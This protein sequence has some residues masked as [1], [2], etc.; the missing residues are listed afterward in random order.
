MKM[1][2]HKSRGSVDTIELNFQKP[3]KKIN[4]L[5]DS[6]ISKSIRLKKLKTLL[7]INDKKILE[8]K[9]KK[10][11]FSSFHMV[12]E[13]DKY[14][15]IQKKL[16]NTI[17][18][19][20]IK[21]LDNYKFDLDLNDLKT[22]Q[23]KKKHR[24]KENVNQYNNKIDDI[25][26]NK[27]R[28]TLKNSRH[29]QKMSQIK[30]LANEINRKIKRIHN[31]YDSFGEDESDK[32][33]EQGNYG[34][35]PR[36][37]FI[38]IYDIFLFL[39]SEF[40]LL[41][42]PYRLAK[43]KMIIE[44]NEYFILSLIIFSEFVFILDLIFGFFRWFYNNEFKL[45]SNIYLIASNYLTGNFI[46]DLIMAI[47]FY[48]IL[49]YKESEKYEYNTAYNESHFWLKIL[50]CFKALKIFKINK[51]KN[52]QVF[53]FFNKR[54][55]K[56]YYIERLYQ[57]I[58]FILLVCSMLHLI[59]CFHIYMAEQSYPNW[60]VSFN[61]QDKSFIE[62]YLASFYFIIA[63]ITSVGYGDI[64]CISSEERYFQI[65]LLSIG[66]V[67]Y[68]WIISAV[69]DYVKNKSRAMDNFN[70][71]MTKLEE[72]RIAYPNMPFKLYNKIQQHIQRMLTQNKKYEYNILVNSLPYYLQNSLLYQIHK[73]EINK[74]T[75]FKD[76]DN[77]DFIL[78]VLTHFIPI[79]SK[80]NIVLVGEGECYENIFFIKE[81]RLSLEAI[82][83]LDYIE[84]SIEKYLKYRFEEIEE[85][86]DFSDHENTNLKSSI[87]DTHKPIIKKGK[88]KPKKLIGM[89]NKQFENVDDI[90]DMNDSNIEQE[91]G[92]CDFHTEKQ[93]I[94]KGNIEYIHILDLLKN[95][96][97]GEILMFLNI[98]NPLSLKVKSKRVEL[99]ILRKKDA[100]N[101][102]KDYQNIWQRIN[103]K[104]I[105]NIK[106]LKSLTLDIINRYCEMNGII[107]KD[108]Q[109]VK[110]GFRTS[111]IETVTNKNQNLFMAKTK[112]KS[113]S[114]KFDIGKKN[115]KR[116]SL[117]SVKPT[118]K[119]LN[120]NE[121]SRKQKNQKDKFNAKKSAKNI[122][123]LNLN[124]NDKDDDDNKNKKEIIKR[125]SLTANFDKGKL[126]KAKNES[127]ESS[128]SSL[129]L[130][131]NKKNINKKMN[132]PSTKKDTIKSNK[133]I[134][135]KSINDKNKQQYPP[136]NLSPNVSKSSKCLQEKN[137]IS[138]NQIQ[139]KNS[140]NFNYIKKESKISFQINSSYKNINEVSKGQYI[141]NS[142]FQNL[143]QKIIK[144]CIK[145]KLI[146]KQIKNSDKF[147]LIKNKLNSDFFKISDNNNN[148]IKSPKESQKNKKPNDI[149]SLLKGKDIIE[150]HESK[151]IN[152]M[153]QKKEILAEDNNINGS[154][155][156]LN[157]DNNIKEEHV[158]TF[159]KIK[160]VD[161]DS[162]NNQEITKDKSVE[163]IYS[164]KVIKNEAG[165]NF[166]EVNLNYVNNFCYIY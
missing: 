58:N 126:T 23:Q 25:S 115:V 136:K 8:I 3:N 121:N 65:I 69:G 82:I 92:K 133:F 68:S 74:F 154:H 64:V 129:S 127:S 24:S 66:L 76:C 85:I 47:P 108:N 91:I 20:S 59:I 107:V 39:A 73:N 43:T 142:S 26:I 134:K 140:Y 61:L 86:E 55:S 98:P 166:Q 13:N 71:D 54:F 5:K 7:S 12:G 159:R 16:Q 48:S 165:S 97:F 4:P 114:N 56:N 101:I 161:N 116:A 41:Y 51:S 113:N 158:Q 128:T 96:Y 95:E 57:I 34:L 149:H 42:M 122:K 31:L 36:S 125:R 139:L 104:S 90:T 141:N 155:V 1:S 6:S 50:I 87:K 88:I 124:L 33:K 132:K 110:S 111:L 84:M 106:S 99:Y 28:P 94:Y 138:N 79:F 145:A 151:K 67:A 37:I 119:F 2:L 120:L 163:N 148:I 100:F 143:I 15:L 131:V 29:S 156:R 83:D 63:T 81:G 44:S 89:I 144:Y 60:I 105:H 9:S 19:L 11:K 157:E 72:I 118:I 30:Q 40:C 32:D 117:T 62:I 10:K 35:N 130:S 38:D 75:F 123:K 78:K 146:Q 22:K 46:F 49:R 109:I 103:K 14:S 162:K 77:S 137:K 70:R 45:V 18:N 93:D 53:Y 152:D 135:P 147:N 102:R 160:E 21:M 112:T 17:L 80:K 52:N 153:N 150:L 164:N 27:T